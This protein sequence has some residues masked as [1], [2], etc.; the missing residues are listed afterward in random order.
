MDSSDEQHITTEKE[1]VDTWASLTGK[2]RDSLFVG[3]VSE[4]VSQVRP[5]FLA[6][7][8]VSWEGHRILIVN[9]ATAVTVVIESADQI[10]GI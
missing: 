8:K 7:K 5:I 1:P 3:T 10:D 2:H 4:H 9:V 6:Y